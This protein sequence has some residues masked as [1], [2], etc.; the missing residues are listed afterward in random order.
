[1]KSVRLLML[2]LAVAAPVTYASQ[3][4]KSDQRLLDYQVASG[5]PADSF[6]YASFWSWEGLDHTHLAVY[7]RG[8]EAYLLTVDSGCGNLALVNSIFVTSRKQEVTAHLD[9]V[10]PEHMI[11][12]TI[13]EIRPVNLSKLKAD[14][15]VQKMRK[16]ED[17]ERQGNKD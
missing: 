1:M 7:T 2:A 14:E 8:D 10:L 3:P 11:P 13:T 9:R 5:A 17:R 6:R 4:G 15:K 12:C 16:I